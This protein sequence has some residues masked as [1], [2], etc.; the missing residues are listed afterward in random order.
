MNCTEIELL[1]N[2]FDAL[3]TITER[4][5]KWMVDY[6]KSG[7]P[8]VE[9]FQPI[10]ERNKALESV[11]KVERHIRGLAKSYAAL[12]HAARRVDPSIWRKLLEVNYALTGNISPL[13][14]PS[15][16]HPPKAAATL[17]MRSEINKTY[18]LHH[19]QRDA[20]FAAKVQLVEFAKERWRISTGKEAPRNSKVG[21]FA[22]FVDA[23]IAYYGKDWSYE[24]AN[25]AFNTKADEEILGEP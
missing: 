19:K 25:R 2:V 16:H 20:E 10:S 12:P 8:I 21:K 6:L 7:M 14:A 22:K 9:S 24:A 13:A 17:A 18:S 5:R 3:P 11:G 15:D 1:Q 4:H 23:L